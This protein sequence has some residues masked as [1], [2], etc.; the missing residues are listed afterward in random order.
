MSKEDMIKESR[1]SLKS[2][3]KT[4]GETKLFIHWKKER[5][6]GFV[7]SSSS[8]FPCHTK[9]WDGKV[10]GEGTGRIFHL[11]IN[12]PCGRQKGTNSTY[13]HYHINRGTEFFL[14][15]TCTP[16]THTRTHLCTE[17]HA[18]TWERTESVSHM[19]FIWVQIAFFEVWFFRVVYLLVKREREQ[20]A[21]SSPGAP[22]SIAKCACLHL[23]I[24]V[25]DIHLV[26]QAEISVNS[27]GDS[28]VR[29]LEDVRGAGC[30]A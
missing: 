27:L 12:Y 13:T 14:I 21:G 5:V 18:Y 6:I 7:R 17:T 2:Q 26:P 19:V 29:W 23:H 28:L 3:R 4:E 11:I 22:G 8:E 20:G 25:L 16:H 24:Y 9:E 30:R 15:L 1:G 10:W